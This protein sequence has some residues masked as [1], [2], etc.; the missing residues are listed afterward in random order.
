MATIFKT[1][2]ADAGDKITIPGSVQVDGSVSIPQGW[3]YDYERPRELS[4]G[5]PDPDYKP[6][7]REE[8]NG[9]MFMATQAIGEMQLQGAA[10]WSSVG[11]PYPINAVVYHNSR[12]WLS[13]AATNN[14]EPG[15]VG[16]SWIDAYQRRFFTSGEALPTAN[17]GPIWHDDYNSLMT[18]QSFTANGASYTGY[19]SQFVGRVEM[20]TQPTARPGYVLCGSQ[21]LAL[22]RTQYAALRAWGLHNGRFVASG[23]WVAG[24]LLMADNPDGVTFRAFDV[25]GEFPRFWDDGRGVDAARVFGSWQADEIKLHGHP[26]AVSHE[27]GGTV[28]DAGYPRLDGSPPVV[29]HPANTAVPSFMNTNGTGNAI[30]G[31]GGSEN[32]TRNTAFLAMLKF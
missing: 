22:S 5:V 31:F 21:S 14:T 2:F 9:L 7:G 30:G 20:D 12:A 16:A 6:V 23:A 32:R 4:P 19:A 1:P 18:W 27:L 26:F 17:V 11:A 15:A 25:R 3:G 24:T 10:S 29:T 13:T 28:D 8:M